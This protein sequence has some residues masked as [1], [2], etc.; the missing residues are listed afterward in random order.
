M[1]RYEGTKTRFNVHALFQL[2]HRCPFNAK[3]MQQMMVQYAFDHMGS[4]I[5]SV[6]ERG[7]HT[8]L[9]AVLRSAKKDILPAISM[10]TTRRWIKHYLFFGETAQETKEYRNKVWGTTRYKRKFTWTTDDITCLKNIIDDKPYLK[11][12]IVITSLYFSTCMIHLHGYRKLVG[13]QIPIAASCQLLQLSPSVA[14]YLLVLCNT[15]E[16]LAH[17]QLPNPIHPCKHA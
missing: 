5:F 4:D 17:N 7:K 14:Y 13:E 9:S 3:T 16:Y 10:S 8:S 12:P 11:S 6:L 2:F 15:L 1:Q